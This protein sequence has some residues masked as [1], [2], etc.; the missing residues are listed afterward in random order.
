MR[1]NEVP[2]FLM[3][4]RYISA[5]I[6]FVVLF[7]VLFLI[8]Y[9]PFSLAVWFSVDDTVSILFTLLFYI[10]STVILILSRWMMYILQD[11][12]LIT[13]IRYVCWIMVENIL[14]TTLYT[15]VTYVYFTPLGISALDVGSRAL[16]CITMMLAIPNGLVSF[17]AAY[18]SKCEDLEA[19]Q[20]ELSR[21]SEEYRRLENR[22]E[23]ERRV[24]EMIP[25]KEKLA[26]SPRMVQL[27][28]NGGTL[29]LTIDV[30]SIYY[31]E[32]ED[33]YIKVYYKHNDKV[34]SYMLRCKTSSVEKSLE[35]SAMVRC[36]RS[37]IVNI[38][39]IRFVG[40]EHRVNFIVM[41][42]DSIKRIP[43]S[44]SYYDT[45][46]ASLNTIRPQRNI[47]VDQPLMVHQ[48]A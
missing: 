31:L 11:R 15:Y 23:V 18:R 33:N 8:T 3:S 42:D 26:L 38:S 47:D 35:G 20:Y 44:K 32:S 7:S 28:D 6:A 4:R 37:Y 48:E 39:K 43:L 14:I 34:S 9:R 29:R 12:Y 17:Y 24:S 41:D 16:F 40:R 1:D 27:Y 13:K 36:H 19:V 22:T 21:V 46:L 2:K 10:T 5:T 30:N 25:V 45:L